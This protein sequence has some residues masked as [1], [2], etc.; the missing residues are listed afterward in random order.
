VSGPD[1]PAVNRYPCVGVAV[2]VR[3]EQG[4]VLMG[5]RA[6]GRFADL[7]CIPCGRLEWGEEVRSGALRE[8]QEE[9]GLVAEIT[10]VAAVHSN[11]HNPDDLSVGIW[12]HG[13]VTGGR[14]YPA[15]GELSE[16]AYFDPASPPALAFP[17]DALVL[18][19]LAGVSLD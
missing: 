3:N 7:W 4:W 5:R 11:F 16:I 14:L 18:A 9:T 19:E 8:L 13:R 1:S 10:G 6:R 2:V 15:D 12:F 17:T